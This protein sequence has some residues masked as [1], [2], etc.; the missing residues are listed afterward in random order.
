MKMY[1]EDNNKGLLLKFTGRTN[2][3]L[4]G[5]KAY[6]F[7]NTDEGEKEL[8]LEDNDYSLTRGELKKLH[9][10]LLALIDNIKGGDYE[11]EAYEQTNN[12]R[13]Y[14]HTDSIKSIELGDIW[15]YEEL[16]TSEWMNEER[17][18]NSILAN[19]SISADFD[20]WYGDSDAEVF[21]V[22]VR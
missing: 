9:P 4:Y 14:F 15:N 22:L 5:F 2:G 16:V 12:G 19:A 8:I 1:V 11:P 20:E 3:I 6:R 21:C 18:N 10:H 7:G 13:D 17:Y